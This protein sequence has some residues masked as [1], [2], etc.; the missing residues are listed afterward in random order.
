MKTQYFALANFTA[1]FPFIITFSHLSFNKLLLN[2]VQTFCTSAVL[3]RFMQS[4]FTIR[5]MES[6]PEPPSPNM[7]ATDSK[8]RKLRKCT[9]CTTRM[10]SFVYDNHLL[11]TK[12][13]NQVCD[14][15][16]VCDE[17]RDWPVTKRKLFVNYNQKLRSKREA[18]RRQ[19][20]LASAA[21]DQ[22][23][24]DTDTDVPLEEP[25]VPVQDIDLDQLNIG[26]QQC[27]TSEEVVISAGTSTDTDST[28]LLVLPP[29]S[30]LD[31]L[32]FTVLSRLSDL[33]SVKAPQTTIQ[34]QSMPA[35]LSQQAL[36]LPNVCQPSVQSLSAGSTI[37]QQGIILPNVCQP[38]VQS[39]SV[40]SQPG[41]ILPNVCQSIFTDNEIEGVA[42]PPPLFINPTQTAFR[43][44]T[45][46]SSAGFQQEATQH[47]Q[48][49]V[50]MAP[51]S[52]GFQQ[53]PT[54]NPQNP[55][56]NNGGFSNLH[57]AL[58]SIHQTIASFTA[59]GMTPPQ[60]LL[61]S[62]SSLARGL[63]DA[64]LS[65]PQPGA[66]TSAKPRSPQ[67]GP[68]RPEATLRV[69]ET[70]RRV[71]ETT[72]RVHEATTR[73]HEATTRV[74]EATAR[75]HEA[76]TRVHEATT[77]VHEAPTRVHEAPTRVHE[78]PTRVHEAPR[79][80]T[81]VHEATR[82][83][84]AT[85]RV[86]EATTRV[87]EPDRRVHETTTRNPRTTRRTPD[88]TQR[89]PDRSESTPMGPGRPDFG[90]T[91]PGPSRRRSFG[92]PRRSSDRSSRQGSQSPPP[93]PPPRKRR[94]HSGNSSDEDPISQN[95]Q[96][97]DDQQ[98]E[99]DNFRPS[100]LDLLLNYI[101]SMFPAASQPVI[102]PSSKRFHIMECAGLVDES[103]QQTS[104]LAWYGCM[105]SAW[106][107]AQ[108][109]FEA[110]VSEGKSLS[111][112]LTTVSKTERVSD[113]P[114]QGRATK[115]NSQ[116]YDLMSSR[117]RESRSVPISVKEATNLETTLRGVM[118]SY[119]FQLWIVTALFRFLGDSGCCP[120]DDPLLDQFQRSFSRGAENVAAALASSTAFVS[121]K[122]RESFLTHMFPSV[123]DAQ[124]RKLLSDPLFDQKD[125]FAPTSIEAAREA[126]RDFS[127]YRGAQSR[128]STSSGSYQRRRFN[129]SNSRGR[130][131]TSPRSNSHRSQPPSSSSGRFQQ[132]KKPSDPPRKRGGFR[133]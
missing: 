16:L 40:I 17:C 13:R 97:R 130:H 3:F 112:I 69:P 6:T 77:R 125:L 70:A 100:S 1:I 2:R 124:K 127:L 42:A 10:P 90:P 57:Q 30:D 120:M 72:T 32:A 74:H 99:E 19:A 54:Q 96:Q 66:S 50:T 128:P 93:P 98:D 73:V 44:P 131:N 20:R 108:R 118:E 114:C 24:C 27:L 83:H 106:D 107:S 129:S 55:V 7:A 75:V 82:V 33:Q 28:N 5:N 110:K 109:K 23:V 68:T 51:S 60:S 31:K 29:G 94:R 41:V 85:T 133:R 47:P 52:R 117:P 105:R 80:C 103:S 76:P 71:Q 59:S 48:N 116:V 36:I 46:P 91:V 49:P 8:Q 62:A 14:M 65:P 38:S 78:A 64:S 15:Q 56:A 113:S 126:A 45:A 11:C 79:G 111:S 87:P 122:R 132:R 9:N 89:T 25:S 119:N 18:K 4:A 58:S 81:R 63:Q 26:Q 39:E 21:S 67:R 12:C 61:D 86:H 34:S 104:N 115:V 88:M 84:K 95:R 121:A 123:T 37:S 35:G 101:T 92:S 22:S 53:E 102:Q 43:P